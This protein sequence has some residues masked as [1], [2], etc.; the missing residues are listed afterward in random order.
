MNISLTF[1][2]TVLHRIIQFG[3]RAND[4]QEEQKRK[5]L[6][7]RELKISRLASL[8]LKRLE[9]AASFQAI[10]N[11]R[12]QQSG[13]GMIE[14]PKKK[15]K[16]I[17]STTT[18]RTK[19]GGSAVGI[20]DGGVDDDV[21]I[22][23]AVVVNVVR[24]TQFDDSID[25]DDDFGA[26][27]LAN[28]VRGGGDDD[29]D[30]ERSRQFF[31][32]S[33]ER[34]TTT[35]ATTN[36]NDIYDDLD[37]T[38]VTKK[39]K[40]KKKKKNETDNNKIVTGRSRSPLMDTQNT[41]TTTTNGGGGGRRVLSFKGRSLSPGQE[42]EEAKKLALFG[43][44]SSEQIRI[45]RDEKLFLEEGG[46][47]GEVDNG[48]EYGNL[49]RFGK[50]ALGETI[51]V[52]DTLVTAPSPPPPQ[53]NNNNNRK[54]ILSPTTHRNKITTETTIKSKVVRFGANCTT[55]E[56][57]EDVEVVGGGGGGEEEGKGKT[58]T[59]K[60]RSMPSSNA[61]AN[62]KR[63]FQ[64]A[65]IGE[66]QVEKETVTPWKKRQA[67]GAPVGMQIDDDDDDEVEVEVEN[68]DEKNVCSSSSSLGDYNTLPLQE[69]FR[70]KHLVD[71]RDSKC[72]A[73]VLKVQVLRDES[74]NNNTIKDTNNN[75]HYVACELDHEERDATEISVFKIIKENNDEDDV[76]DD[77]RRRTY[78]NS[79]RGSVMISKPSLRG[80][81]SDNS[82]RW[83]Y[84]LAPNGIVFT[85]MYSTSGSS[86]MDDDDTER[87]NASQEQPERL[88]SNEDE[89]TLF[90]DGERIFPTRSGV[91]VQ[92]P[93]DV[94]NKRDVA[95]LSLSSSSSSFFE[96]QSPGTTGT[97]MPR[98]FAS[99]F[100]KEFDES[101][102]RLAGV[103]G[104]GKCRLW[105]WSCGK[106]KEEEENNGNNNNDDEEEKQNKTNFSSAQIC[107]T[108][109]KHCKDFEIPVYK[110]YYVERKCEVTSLS[111]SK[112]GNILACVFDRK[113]VVVWDVVT[114]KCVFSF[115]LMDYEVETDGL[116]LI[117]DAL[118]SQ[119]KLKKPRRSFGV[120][121]EPPIFFFG[122]F[123]KIETF[124]PYSS[125]D[126]D[127]DGCKKEV[128]NNNRR[129]ENQTN[130]S[131]PSF[132][133]AH[134]KQ[135]FVGQNASFSRF[136]ENGEPVSEQISSIGVAPNIFY[137]DNEDD[138]DEDDEDDKSK[139]EEE[140]NN[141]MNIICT[142]SG[143]LCVHAAFPA[144]DK[145]TNKLIGKP[146][147]YIERISSSEE[148]KN[149]NNN[150]C[151]NNVRNVQKNRS[152]TCASHGKLIAV[153]TNAGILSVYA[154]RKT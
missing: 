99:A 116:Q 74:K 35:T 105:T 119:S 78:A 91:Y 69:I 114:T 58:R 34:R 112:D 22:D 8:C 92:E 25:D 96:L 93:V 154:L 63:D 132:A 9:S 98:K 131:F 100:S 107:A 70:A 143:Y 94:N 150:N 19:I 10:A 82:K 108:S 81:A 126:D 137:S 104:G 28:A 145:K 46:G 65:T 97:A 75:E 56:E 29:D 26:A 124:S 7:Q 17:D 86:F 110:T 83:T 33:G 139:A 120:A 66:K 43:A 20:G 48:D 15:K 18:D 52:A 149:N 141:T 47:G 103:G 57:V 73:P 2:L 16:I 44:E 14:T 128:D 101:V 102:F 152:F 142:D 4:E 106:S 64:Q 72:F 84:A 6:G 76:D 62:N 133:C 60:K 5:R 3:A 68:D 118:V 121:K 11:E 67:I 54:S 125:D 127:D 37:M 61:T 38:T 39:K 117:D 55:E 135:F 136:D 87:T 153:G 151:N 31:S 147:A 111:F 40:E 41:T 85:S 95:R 80:P 148:F 115:Y 77:K 130:S 140:G 42:F 13:E 129:K 12:E 32:S 122:N 138:D 123:K 30:D 113:H 45:E 36:N 89:C 59:T 23:S 49:D 27:Q 88:F 71:P 109:V 50:N 134:N 21:G 53:T 144:I 24:N 51:R 79:F 1:E 90:N 146:L